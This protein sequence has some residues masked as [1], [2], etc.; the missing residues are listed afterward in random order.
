MCPIDDHKL[1]KCWIQ[2]NQKTA[3]S[4]TEMS[5]DLGLSRARFYQLLNQGIFPKPRYC[6]ETK[7]PYYDSELQETCHSV[8]RKNVG[9]NGRT[10][11]FYSPRRPVTQKAKPK[12]SKKHVELIEALCN[13]GL[14]NVTH[15]QANAA[16]KTCFPTGTTEVDQAEIIRAVFVHLKCQ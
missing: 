4:V 16:I 1:T 9:I 13:L 14:A 11:L 7:R 2:M 3:I 10:I 5:K 6:E 12:Q 15:D 8:R